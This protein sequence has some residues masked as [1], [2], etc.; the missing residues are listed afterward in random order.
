MIPYGLVHGNQ[1]FRVGILLVNSEK[2]KCHSLYRN[3]SVHKPERSD[4]GLSMIHDVNGHRFLGDFAKIAKR[5][6]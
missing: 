3:T 1:R 2:K 5:D 6:Y 4:V